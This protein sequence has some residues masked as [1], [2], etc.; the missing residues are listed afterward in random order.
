MVWTT[1]ALPSQTLSTMVWRSSAKP[2]AWRT[3]GSCSSVYGSCP[4]TSEIHQHRA[5]DRCI[6]HLESGAALER[7]HLLARQVHDEVDLV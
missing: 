1:A 7:R 6:R 4:W 3:A 2:M 5:A